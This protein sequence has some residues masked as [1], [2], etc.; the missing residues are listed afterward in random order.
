M[1][2]GVGEGEMR[3]VEEVAVELEFGLEVGVRFGEGGEEWDAVRGSVEVVADDGVAEGLHVD[4]D[5]MCAA[6]LDADFDEG[7]G[8]VGGAEALEYVDVGYGGT[9]AF[10]EGSASGHAD[11]ADEVSGD[12]EVDGDVVF[13]QM[14][15]DE[16][17]VGFGD[18]AGGEHVAELAM[19]AVVFGDEDETAG[20]LV[21][22]VDDAGA[23]IAADLG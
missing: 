13:C 22:A 6:G 18:L 21:E 20:L 23:E 10:A 8:A 7:E 2:L 15:V 17:D 9:D 12:G 4:A 1:G 5:L 3:G 11:A 16:G 14:A 19:G